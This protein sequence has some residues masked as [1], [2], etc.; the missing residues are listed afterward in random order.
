MSVKHKSK[1]A[2]DSI[3]V[4]AE[5][6][7]KQIYTEVIPSA[8]A[9]LVSPTQAFSFI[10]HNQ[11]FGLWLL[12]LPFLHSGCVALTRYSVMPAIDGVEEV[13]STFF[14]NGLTGVIVFWLTVLM[15]GVI[16]KPLRTMPFV[17]L[18][19]ICSWAFLSSALFYMMWLL[20]FIA[21]PDSFFV[22]PSMGEISSPLESN[23]VLPLL[24]VTDFFMLMWPIVFLVYMAAQAAN[25]SKLKAFA[26]IATSFIAVRLSLVV[27]VTASGKIFA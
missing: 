4:R 26:I 3:D 9:Q 23:R 22:D 27:L 2:P 18:L 14:V 12:I 24:S 15:M 1:D 17:T 5:Q 13:V 7:A 11:S 19:R 21:F 25:I 10:K 8:W 6:L 16:S 20:R